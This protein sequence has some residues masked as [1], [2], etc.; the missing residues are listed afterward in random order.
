MP[1]RD[2]LGPIDLNRPSTSSSSSSSRKSVKLAPIFTTKS[3]TPR[4]QLPLPPSSPYNDENSSPTPHARKRPRLDLSGAVDR[5]DEE[6]VV[7]RPICSKRS[8]MADFFATTGSSS[9]DTRSRSKQV[10]T[11]SPELPPVSVAPVGWIRKRSRIGVNGGRGD[12]LL[13]RATTSTPSLRV[14][15]RIARKLMNRLQYPKID[16]LYTSHVSCAI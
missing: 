9:S 4:T 7:E 1:T 8:S 3:R 5:R 6:D 10:V 11:P 13:M 15:V 2:P 14:F 16:P 12:R